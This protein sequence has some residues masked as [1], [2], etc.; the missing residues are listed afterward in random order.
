MA[1]EPAGWRD[2]LDAWLGAVTPPPSGPD[3][4][5]YREDE[6][7]E[8]PFN[9][10][11]MRRLLGYVRPYR[12]LTVAGTV[13]TLAGAGTQLVRPVLLGLAVNVISA[14]GATGATLTHRA[15][16]LALYALLY[17]ASY[18]FN[19]GAGVLQ[20]RLTAALGQR[21]LVDLRTDLYAHIQGLSL[22]FFDRHSV[23]SVLVRVT[24]D[25]NAL[26]DLFTNGIVTLL[27]N[28]F[29]LIGIVA[30]MLVL[31]WNLALACFA[32]IPL[33]LAISTRMRRQIRQSWQ[34]VRRRLTRI[35]AHLN[36][37]IQG[38][39]VTQAFTAETENRR[40]FDGINYE[41]F[42]SWRLAQRWSALFGPLVTVTG[43]LGT[44]VVFIYGSELYI[45]GRIQ[46]E[47]VVMFL[48]YVAMF[49]SPIAQI[50]NL[51]N[52]LLQAMASSERIFQ[53]LD[54]QAR[55]ASPPGAPDLPPV[56][57]EVAFED[58]VFSYDG[59]RRALDGVNFRAA[60]G[61][62]VALVGH[63][64]AGKTSVVSMLTRLYDPQSG[65]ILIDGHDVRAVSLPSLRRQVG[66]VLQETV[67]FSGTVRENLRYGRLDAS[68]DEV[69]A[70]ARAVDA[71]GF[72]TALPRGYDT[73]VGERGGRFS[74]GQRQLLAF[75]RALVADPRILVLDEA[76][77]SIDTQTEQ[78]VQ[79]ALAR[80]LEGRTAFVVAHRL[81]TI[82]RADRILVFAHGRIVEAGTH[83][84][85]LAQEGVYLELL[86][87][88]YRFLDAGGAP[89]R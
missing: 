19:W 8:R 63:T 37:A 67:L 52:S 72:I 31:R 30:V 2:R 6:D 70:A 35:N 15:H 22:D 48:Q 71:H 49:W 11:Q 47:L 10:S 40:F 60:P 58:V 50:G 54:F 12:W 13:A 3:R 83:V 89:R 86:R 77:S 7:I 24:N 34:R 66:T 5:L 9:W 32:V 53:F 1:A 55:V 61:E 43:A 59:R 56:R 87:A 75:A 76:T 28:A 80:L 33:M 73:E 18:V 69:E 65:R 64:G 85:L 84:Q 17:L 62:T 26:N 79:A 38:I 57:G 39:R 25:V 42:A 82:R 27:S 78:K 20:T 51:Y 46:V 81:S 14:P 74:V 23:G 68:D 36:E 29:L 16:R 45:H 4:F 21:V 88:Q 41:Y 44:A